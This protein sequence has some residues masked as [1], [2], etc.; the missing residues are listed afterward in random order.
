MLKYIKNFICEKEQV[1][2]QIRQIE[3]KRNQ[4]A[5]Q[6]N[7]KKK[8]N[9][10][11]IEINELGRQ[12][13]ELGNQSQELQ[14][15]LDFKSRETKT[16]VNFMID[17]FV[18]EGIRK[19]RII[20][21]TIQEL[22]EKNASQK[23]RVAK[24]EIQKEEFFLRFGRM[25]ELSERAKKENELQEK[26]VAKSE[27]E[28]IQMQQQI[29]EIKKEIEVL[30]TA[31]RNLKNGNWNVV[32]EIKAVDEEIHIEELNVEEIQP[33]E[34]IYVEDF[35][36][37]EE[38]YVE[39]FEPLEELIIEEFKIEEFEEIN[40]TE[41]IIEAEEDAI[42]EI[43]KLARAIIEEIAAE[44]TKDNSV[45]EAEQ[46]IAEDIVKFEIEE[47]KTTKSKVII[48][49]FG[50]K[51][52]ISTIIVKIEDG[53]LVYKAQ[54]SDEEEIKIY[55]SKLGENSVLLRDRQNRDECREILANYSINE[56]KLLDKK[57]I[58]K[59]DP[60]VCELLIECA[61][62]YE[63]DAQELIYNYAMS[64]SNNVGYEVDL[65]PAIIYN[66]SYIEA[67]NLSRKE[68]AVM[69]KIC[70]NARKNEKIDIIES[71]AGFKKFKYVLKRLFAINNVKVLP[72]AKY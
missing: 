8:L 33:I 19:I 36:E 18:A 14:K 15:N 54:M 61:E 63:Y 47:E 2:K 17:N 67:S 10:K 27:L 58:N 68:K 60:L 64:F 29:D 65:V 24:Y 12:I 37:I 28:I 25:P 9:S 57:V 30:A 59:I 5:G 42:D 23:E 34:E 7:E 70:R 53:E 31:K 45:I 11:D 16:Q 1:Q 44:Q 38:L 43:E 13:C 56:H 3:E 72:E 41:N 4:L 39:E 71:F 32:E 46:K 21:Q 51:A 66:L 40:K 69:N 20:D 26:E 48:P 22:E 52:T 6:R 50:Q 55:P 62:E 35:G 49:L